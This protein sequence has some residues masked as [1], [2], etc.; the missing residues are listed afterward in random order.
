MPDRQKT[1]DIALKYPSSWISNCP[2]PAEV[3]FDPNHGGGL[4]DRRVKRGSRWWSAAGVPGCPKGALGGAPDP[5][6]AV[7]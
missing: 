2:A 6:R 3:P 1:E 7:E 5:P 4:L